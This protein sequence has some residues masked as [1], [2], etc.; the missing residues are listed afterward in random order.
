MGKI[1]KTNRKALSIQARKEVD[2][3]NLIYINQEIPID[4]Q[5]HIKKIS[6]LIIENDGREW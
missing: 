2:V 3:L 6:K 1:I 5:K 4:I